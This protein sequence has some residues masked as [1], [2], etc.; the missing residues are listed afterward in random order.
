MARVSEQL[1]VAGR[2][3]DAVR[4]QPECVQRRYIPAPTRLAELARASD[5]G[6]LLFRH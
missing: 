5:D 1:M 4:H 3:T 6:F 2:L